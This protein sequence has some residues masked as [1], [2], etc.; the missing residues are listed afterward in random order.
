[1]LQK[2]AR[3]ARNLYAVVETGSIIQDLIDMRAELKS[4]KRKR[5]PMSQRDFAKLAGVNYGMVQRIEAG[6]QRTIDPADLAKWL[7]ACGSSAT[8]YFGQLKMLDDLK[9]LSEDLEIAEKFKK[10]LKIPAKRVT[11]KAFLDG[12]VPDDEKPRDKTRPR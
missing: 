10:A 12:L 6:E 1:L 9:V 2:F 8:I 5:A 11:L 4:D 3:A 7:A